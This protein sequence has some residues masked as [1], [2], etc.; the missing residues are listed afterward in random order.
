MGVFCLLVSLLVRK[1]SLYLLGALRLYFFH[2]PLRFPP[3][4]SIAGS[5]LRSSP[6]TQKSEAVWFVLSAEGRMGWGWELGV[7]HVLPK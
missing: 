2:W 7:T 5:A 3:A 6:D 4:V 1:K